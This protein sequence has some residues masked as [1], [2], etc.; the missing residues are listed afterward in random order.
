MPH[1]PENATMQMP[2]VE[3]KERCHRNISQIYNLP[4]E[5]IVQPIEKTSKATLL[6]YFCQSI[7]FMK[8][9][10]QLSFFSWKLTYVDNGATVLDRCNTCMQG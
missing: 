6:H 1:W 5:I 9:I 10:L 7:H 4:Q 8:V 2:V 3:F